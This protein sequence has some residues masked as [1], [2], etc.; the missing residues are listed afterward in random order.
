M[1]LLQLRGSFQVVLS[2]LQEV[3]L[4]FGGLLLQVSPLLF[5]VSL[6]SLQA[7]AERL[8]GEH[9]DGLKILVHGVNLRLSCDV[10]GC[11]VTVNGG[12]CNA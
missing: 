7:L 5:R 8:D 1:C 11:S 3:E 4:V 10:H 2:L 9:E 6:G 12:E